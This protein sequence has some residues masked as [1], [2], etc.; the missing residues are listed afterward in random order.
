MK[1][2]T[3]NTFTDGMVKDLHP[4]T[5]PKTVLTDALNATLITYDGNEYILQNDMGNGK[6]ETSRLPKG[7][8][9]VGMT[10]YG[11]IIYVASYNPLTKTSQIGSFPSPER[12]IGTEE[13]DDNSSKNY[14]IN[15]SINTDNSYIRLDVVG[16]DLEK[17]KLNPG[18]KFMLGTNITFSDML[19]VHIA[20]VDKEGNLTYIDDQLQKAKFVSLDG[21]KTDTSDWNVFTG[22]T[23]GYLTII[24]ALSTIDTFD[25]TR[26]IKL[27]NA[28]ITNGT[29]TTFDVTFNG[30]ATNTGK[31]SANGFCMNYDLNNTSGKACGA[32]TVK[33]EEFLH[34]DILSYVAIPYCAYGYLNA[35]KISGKI[36]FSLYGTG[37][38]K[39]T[40]WRYYKD[41][42]YMKITWGLDYDVI[43]FLKVT[44]V[45]FFLYNFQDDLQ[46]AKFPH[47]T[48]TKKSTGETVT[49]NGYYSYY[50]C[51]YKD[52]YNGVF[53]EK[54][55][56]QYN[57]TDTYGLQKNTLYFVKIAVDYLNQSTNTTTT[58][59]YY[60]MLYTTGIFN[61][62]YIKYN[63][64]DFKN[65]SPKAYISISPSCE[66]TD[67]QV[68]DVSA[69]NANEFLNSTV[70]SK[71]VNA[72][73]N[74]TGNVSLNAKVTDDGIP[75]TPNISTNSSDTG[76][77][78]VTAR[79]GN[80]FTKEISEN[81]VYL[82]TDTTL[83]SQLDTVISTAYPATTGD[84]SYGSIGSI[85]INNDVISIQG[86]IRRGILYS[87]TS[88]NNVAAD[89]YNI[90]KA[91][92]DVD[93]FKLKYV[94]CECTG[95]PNTMV[96]GD[97]NHLQITSAACVST[98]KSLELRYKTFEHTGTP[99]SLGA[100]DDGGNYV[101][102]QN[103]LNGLD[104]NPFNKTDNNG[105]S[106]PITAIVPSSVG[107]YP[108][109]WN[110]SPLACIKPTSN[111]INGLDQYPVRDDDWG[112]YD[113]PIF[114]LWK[115]S[116]VSGAWTFINLGGIRAW[117]ETWGK[118][119]EVI[120]PDTSWP[121]LHK[122]S[123]GNDESDKWKA[124]GCLYEYPRKIT[125]Q[126]S[127]NANTNYRL[128]T[129]D[130][131]YN[132]LNQF[133][134]VQWG[135]LTFTSKVPDANHI[136]YNG[137]FDNKF[138]ITSKYTYTYN[139]SYLYSINTG[140]S[141]VYLNPT[142]INSLITTKLVG[143]LTD[144]QFTDITANTTISNVTASSGSE[145]YSLEYSIGKEVDMSNWNTALNEIANGDISIDTSVIYD[146]TGNTKDGS[147]NPYSMNSI[148][149]KT[150]GGNYVIWDGMA[151]YPNSQNIGVGTDF[152]HV[153]RATAKA[154]A[155]LYAKAGSRIL[156][157]NKTDSFAVVGSVN[158][159][160]QLYPN[161]RIWPQ[162]EN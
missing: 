13:I 119:E 59:Y 138:K 126:L 140:S 12:Q 61:E 35:F 19:D 58:K 3:V 135:R 106:C 75:G 62:D 146:S 128:T 160:V 60:R 7:Y 50:E 97:T 43:E 72:G 9:P 120:L 99:K 122:D 67:K 104:M 41:N 91:F 112:Y 141:S 150:S 83:Q 108:L 70:T 114:I 22:K 137:L 125:A 130:I 102:S 96:T 123:D 153:E 65:L 54:I 157:T 101:G 74:V 156:V 103:S 31:V 37:F 92:S 79:F 113:D 152:L 39:L 14:S 2:E 44:S 81:K 48:T 85:A 147:G 1:Q 87:G 18:D 162:T 139:P 133:Y 148:Y 11:G 89:C 40:E 28:D 144:Y 17:Y 15:T 78:G 127:P 38:S 116:T 27:H 29:N 52:N 131:L 46:A 121:P 45:K 20:I 100:N 56:F 49:T 30:V 23:S 16:S 90:T 142:D 93:D 68:T 26:D 63:E 117:N 132:F 105:M 107:E 25:L 84:D 136:I 88:T 115:T 118:N 98:G 124:D 77:Y 109:G 42:D 57:S 21:L 55:P 8:V 94:G 33:M 6:V 36:D 80:E 51:G 95:T 110:T 129:L 10:E 76:N 5:T 158:A 71:V 53:S 24:I 111:T 32:W 69:A 73:Y 64:V 4:L 155:I 154:N 143:Q 34:S 66:V 149:T 82:G 145:D 159:R 161:S 86:N 47:I 134:V 151:Y